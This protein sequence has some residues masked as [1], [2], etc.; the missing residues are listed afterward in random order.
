MRSSLTRA[1]IAPFAVASAAAVGCAMPQLAPVDAQGSQAQAGLRGDELVSVPGPSLPPGAGS[2]GP[3]RSAVRP[4]ELL[5]LLREERIMAGLGPSS[6]GV[7]LRELS[8]EERS[9]VL[10]KTRDALQARLA[11][12]GVEVLKGYDN[13]PAAVV[14]ASTSQ[15]V[16]ALRADALVVAVE[17]MQVLTPS[18]TESFSLVKQPAALS[19]GVTGAGTAVVVL[20][21]GVDYTQPS[22][23]PC[24]APGDPPPCRVPV[25]EDFA[26]PDDE[27]DG[28]SRHGTNVSG[29]IAEMAPGVD[30][31]GL[32][33]FDNNVASPVA[34]FDAL[35]WS[36]SNRD[37]YGIVAVNMSL[38]GFVAHPTQE[39]C[40]STYEVSVPLL[41]AV[42]DAG[43]VLVA[44]SG[45][46]ARTD[47]ITYPG[48]LS[49]V[50]SVGAV[51]DKAYE[52]FTWGNGVCTDRDVVRDQICCFS[53]SAPFLTLLAPG[54]LISGA[55][56][57]TGGTSQAAP[58]VAGAI[59]L[60]SE[61]FPFESPDQRIARLVTTGVPLTD[62]RNG[63][64]TPRLDVNKAVRT[65]L[66]SIAPP[67]TLPALSGS[68]DL[69]VTSSCSWTAET[70]ADWLTIA[71]SDG[72][73]GDGV[74]TLT[75]A[76]NA[77]TE[78]FRLATVTFTFPDGAIPVAVTQLSDRS[79]PTGLVAIN[80]GDT[81]SSTTTVS[82]DISGSDVSSVSSMCVSAGPRC[83][84]FEDFTETRTFTLPSGDGTR[85][86]R[87]WLR[88]A[89]GNT[90]TLQTAASDSIELDVTP[91]TDGTVGFFGSAD[92]RVLVW[93]GFADARSGL[94]RYRVAGAEG[95]VPPASC[96]DGQLIYEGTASTMADV[97]MARGATMSYRVCAV[98]VA[99]NVSLGAVVFGVPQPETDP[100][101]GTVLVNGGAATTSSRAVTV[102]VDARDFSTVSRMCVSST[103]ACALWTPYRP[104]A[105][106]NLSGKDG[107]K[108]VN[109]W[110]EDQWG[111]V[112][113][114]PL[115]G[116]IVLDTAAPEQGA[117]TAEPLDAAVAL[118]W[119]GFDDRSGIASY[120][121][122]FA[123]SRIAPPTCDEGTTIYEGT[124][125]AFIH[126]GLVNGALHSY[127]LCA[128]DIVG[129]VS[130]GMVVSSI[131]RP[132]HQPPSGTAV[133]AGGDAATRS[134]T[135]DLQIDATDAS[136]VG[137]ICIS[138]GDTCSTWQAWT[139]TR[140]VHLS[141]GDGPKTVRVWLRDVWYN[142]TPEPLEARILLDTVPPT[143]GAVTAARR[144]DATALS[145]SGFADAAS[146]IARYRVVFAA[147]DAPP[148]TC[149]RGSLV[150]E[151]TRT[152]F[153]HLDLAGDESHAYRVCA[154]DAAGNASR[155]AVVVVP[156]D[157]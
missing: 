51:Y 133:L 67:S 97:S 2:P 144:S 52:G 122:T 156:A 101:T 147:G 80:G 121:V 145:W 125:P 107:I 153:K 118:A 74:L 104:A 7:R 140:T 15:A 76:S 135:V 119:E 65:C 30:V 28:P 152:T 91:P 5:V 85:T 12:A 9:A 66:A 23:G 54:A 42:R 94:S 84:E 88:D 126:S 55:G 79:P 87:V 57:T 8:V 139:P 39:D 72:G 19:T 105:A 75:A 32:D 102:A 10:A 63:I 103:D 34:L 106:F 90:S 108:D 99:G 61:A 93:S 53:N 109:V 18:D 146:G 82:L 58:H 33:V 129:N 41:Q 155:G 86:V 56:E 69:L 114:E 110:L 49:P 111:N 24:T 45:N 29:I 62:P 128:V 70:D 17:A 25:A 138:E 137:G 142:A 115:T 89:L 141:A 47:G 4:E 134:S 131:P 150:Y 64:T 124:Q 81:W 136:G 127:R 130:A 68:L 27:V 36:I 22:F 120:R 1:L 20:D 71:G 3:V 98:D 77:D 40:D 13:F 11:H 154:V 151:G 143:D 148:S 48:C 123:A 157:G 50:V 117:F 43:I 35:D 73:S 44:A 132:E 95:F 14:R 59:A 149:E 46:G 112:T 38:G 16:A 113:P 96:A 26:L 31:I 21:T 83:T 6:G 37:T 60:V 100:P 116:R 92:A 78:S